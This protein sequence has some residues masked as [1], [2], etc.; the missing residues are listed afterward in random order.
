VPGTSIITFAAGQ[1]IAGLGLANTAQEN[2]FN[3]LNNSSGTA[4]VVLDTDGYFEP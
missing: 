1:A 3:I 4:N 2:A